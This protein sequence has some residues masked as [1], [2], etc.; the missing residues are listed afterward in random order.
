MTR[1]EIGVL[2]AGIG[3][4]SLGT[5]VL[6]CLIAAGGYRVYGCDIS[7]LAYGHFQ[8]GFARTFTLERDGYAAAVLDLCLRLGVRAVIPGGEEPMVLLGQGANEFQRRGVRVASNDPAVVE[9]C[10]NKGALFDRLTALGFPIPR[11]VTVTTP[12]EFAEVGYPCVVKAA[13]GTGGSSYVFLAADRS[14]VALYL[15][16]ILANRPSAVVQEYVPLDGGEYTIG[17]LSL[18]DGRLVGAVAM[19][20]LFHSKLSVAAR[21]SCGLISSGYSQGWIGSVPE[22]TAQAEAI[23]RGLGSR[24]PINVQARV[25]DGV[26]LPFEVNPRFSAST[27]LRTLAGCNEIDVYLRAVLDGT[28]PVWGP[29]RAGHYLRSLAEVVV[30][31]GERHE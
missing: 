20:R 15:S 12:D 29:V 17:V 21:T 2:I 30:P 18:P 25:R 3:G 22:L 28:D 5:E 16:H 19:K 11:T 31:T 6:K 23:A 8:P 10:S 13:T 7:P 9:L 14:E 26:L 4:A 27:Y 1:G 24:G